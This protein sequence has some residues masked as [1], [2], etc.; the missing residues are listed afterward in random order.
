MKILKGLALSL[1][2]FLLFLSLSIFG[3]AF[4]LNKTLLD[5]DFVTAELDRLDTS[6]L[7]R[8]F[9]SLSIQFPPE[10]LYITETIN[11]TITDLEPWMREQLNIATYASYDYFLGNSQSLNLVIPLEPVTES[12]RDNL[13]Q[14][15]L[16]SP[17]PELQ[18]M[19]PA[20]KERYFNELYQQLAD[21]IPTTFEFTES[22]LPPPR[23]A[24]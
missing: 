5:P 21:N 20:V 24:G 9:I 2:S 17:P 6:S 13:W 22:S 15:F 12:F 10:T 11:K 7:M 3:L 4:M 23:C 8:E 14:A 18:S 1:L 16:A 19:P